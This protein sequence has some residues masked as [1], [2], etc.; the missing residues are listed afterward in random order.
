MMDSYYTGVRGGGEGGRSGELRQ[1][2]GYNYLE[3][4]RL[5]DLTA[6]PL[7][8]SRKKKTKVNSKTGL[9]LF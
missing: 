2:F 6:G 8:W 3:I 9:A 1:Y 4:M 5:A 7:P